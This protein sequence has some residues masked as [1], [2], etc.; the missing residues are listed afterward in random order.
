MAAPGDA[1]NIAPALTIIDLLTRIVKRASICLPTTDAGTLENG[2]APKTLTKT[3]STTGDG[4]IL[5]FFVAY[6][7]RCPWTPTDD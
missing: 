4:E 5:G 3:L 6:P 2:A 7:G 1:Y